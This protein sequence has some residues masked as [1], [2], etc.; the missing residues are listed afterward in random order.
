MNYCGLNTNTS[1]QYVRNMLRQLGHI[2]RMIKFPKKNE[3]IKKKIQTDKIWREIVTGIDI[4][5]I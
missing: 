5:D 4:N 2:E 1:D 3:W